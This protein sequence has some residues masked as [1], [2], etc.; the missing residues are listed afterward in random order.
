MGINYPGQLVHGCALSL[1]EVVA[2]G[3]CAFTF[4]FGFQSFSFP[5]LCRSTN[6]SVEF[7]S[8][9]F[10]DVLPALCLF[11]VHHP[12]ARK[13]LTSCQIKCPSSTD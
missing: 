6:L 5:L 4:Q 10:G 1:L 8:Y 13:N 11:P 7:L 3:C 2:G 9:T 12:H